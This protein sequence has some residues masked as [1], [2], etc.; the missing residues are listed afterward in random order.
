[1][2]FG[3]WRRGFGRTFVISPFATLVMFSLFVASVVFSP[4]AALDFFSRFSFDLTSSFAGGLP[5]DLL[6]PF[7][8]GRK[9]PNML[10]FAMAM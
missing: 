3:I 2:R 7:F 8:F 1:L 10:F 4:F 5:S 6:A 9:K